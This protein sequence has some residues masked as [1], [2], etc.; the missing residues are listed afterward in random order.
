M[1]TVCTNKTQLE[2]FVDANRQ[3]ETVQKGLTDYLET[4]RLAFAR[5]FFLSDGDILQILS[6]TRNPLAVQDHLSKCFEAINELEFQ[7]DM[8]IVGM[9]SKEGEYVE[10]KTSMYP[11]GNVE[12]WLCKVEECMFESVREQTLAAIADY[13]ATPRIDWVRKWPGMTVLCVAGIFWSKQV[14][15]GAADRRQTGAPATRL[16]ERMRASSSFPGAGRA[17][18]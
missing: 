6:Q 15:P 8:E 10:F 9:H 12:T 13:Q 11:E 2:L 18:D 17:G 16:C 3:L 4:K 7:D 5:F 1:L 14:R